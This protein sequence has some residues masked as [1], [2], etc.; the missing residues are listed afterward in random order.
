MRGELTSDGLRRLMAALARAAP[1]SSR[2]RVYV[3]GGGTAVLL[4]WREATIDADLF[5]EQDEVFRTVQEIKERLQI[6]IEF[7]RP[8]HFVPALTGA[9]DRHVFIDKI[10]NV[11]FFH[12]DPYSQLLSKIVRGFRKDLLDAE[13]FLSSGMVEPGQFRQC[14]DQIPD[15]AYAKYPALSRDAVTKA[16]NG[17][18]GVP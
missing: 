6:S 17:I 7:V 16:V 9:D 15:S 4:G 14:V 13:Q 1:D 2:F 5:S 11:D 10:G 18:L 12:Y 3:L 8:E